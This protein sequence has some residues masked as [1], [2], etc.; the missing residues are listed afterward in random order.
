MGSLWK[1]GSLVCSFRNSRSTPD[2]RHTA[3]RPSI[4]PR[5]FP[6]SLPGLSSLASR[7]SLSLITISLRSDP[8]VAELRLSTRTPQA[9]SLLNPDEL[10]L[11]RRPKLTVLLLRCQLAPPIR[12]HRRDRQGFHLSVCKRPEIDC[13]FAHPHSVV[14]LKK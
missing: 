7:S 1:L 2:P 10:R 11:R 3:C 13:K 8:E 6:L 4:R 14:G 12:S 5:I 9:P